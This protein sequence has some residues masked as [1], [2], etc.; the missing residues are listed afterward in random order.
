MLSMNERNKRGRLDQ[1]EFN[2]RVV[3]IMRLQDAFRKALLDYQAMEK[4]SRNALRARTERQ[5]RLGEFGDD[6]FLTKPDHLWGLILFI[7]SNS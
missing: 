5:Y 6:S 4:K 7:I 1:Q 2:T 3:H